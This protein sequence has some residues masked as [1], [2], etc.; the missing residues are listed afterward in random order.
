MLV[1]VTQLLKKFLRETGPTVEVL[2]ITSSSSFS[3]E[4]EWIAFETLSADPT[5]AEL[6][7]IKKRALADP[8]YFSRCKDCGAFNPTGLMHD[9]STCHACAEQSL[10]TLH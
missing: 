3:T 9:P 10:G 8:R 4:S 1:N 6:T 2:K 5:H 7:A